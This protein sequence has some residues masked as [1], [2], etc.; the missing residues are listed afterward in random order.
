ML[1]DIE[2]MKRR[3]KEME[4]EAAKLQQM[5]AEIEKDMGPGGA[6]AEGGN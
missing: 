1:Q 5:Q 2:S 6:S 4:E 3:M